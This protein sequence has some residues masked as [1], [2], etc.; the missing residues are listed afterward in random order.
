MSCRVPILLVRGKILG[1]RFIYKSLLSHV[2]FADFSDKIAMVILLG[3][4]EPFAQTSSDFVK[5]RKKA[6]V[7][8]LVP[9]AL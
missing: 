3:S 1:H 2:P 7:L 6:K 4:C 9:R 5:P 8:E